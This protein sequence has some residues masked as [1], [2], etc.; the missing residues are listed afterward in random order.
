MARTIG[1]KSFDVMRGTIKQPAMRVMAD[2]RLGDDYETWIEQ[3]KRGAECQ[4][5]TVQFVADAA[6]A[7]TEISAQ[8]ALAGTHVTV[9]DALGLTTS[10]VQVI[11]VD[12]SARAVVRSGSSQIRIQ[13]AWTMRAGG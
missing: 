13:T 10:N 4:L 11:R 12:A 2:E 9:V 7:Q 5:T 8:Y 1:A 6:A 3:G